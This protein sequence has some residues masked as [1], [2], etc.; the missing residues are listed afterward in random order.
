MFDL[1]F[2]Q[3]TD[4]ISIGNLVDTVN[5]PIIINA[6]LAANAKP[7]LKENNKPVLAS[8]KK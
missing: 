7:R 3:N 1:I 8:I 6:P 4:F 5:V 2:L